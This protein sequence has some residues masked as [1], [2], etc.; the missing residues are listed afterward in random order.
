MKK[1][2]TALQQH[3]EDADRHD[4]LDRPEHRRPG[5]VVLLIVD[6]GVLVAGDASREE[7]GQIEDHEED[8]DGVGLRAPP[9][10]Q[11]VVEEVHA[12]MR[13]KLQRIG[14][15]EQVIGGEQELGH[16]QRPVHRNAEEHP[17]GRR[18]EQHRGQHVEQVHGEAPDD[19]VHRVDGSNERSY[20]LWA[21]RPRWSAH[22]P[23]HCIF[24]AA[25]FVAASRR[26][27]RAAHSCCA[28]SV[29]RRSL[30][31]SIMAQARPRA[32]ACRE[33]RVVDPVGRR[34]GLVHADVE[35]LRSQAGDKDVGQGAVAVEDDSYLPRPD[36][37]AEHAR[38]AVDGDQGRGEG[39]RQPAFDERVDAA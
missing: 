30:R 19:A 12:D 14:A 17:P 28:S 5:R 13:A 16:L 11:P 21:S 9:R 38:K 29:S 33:R 27:R 4:D 1:F 24:R 25:T 18:V 3:E 35:T 34:I 39:R 6:D 7:D 10:R 15:A 32:S 36:G 8:G 2:E 37:L 26:A 31:I 22:A 23:H 20:R